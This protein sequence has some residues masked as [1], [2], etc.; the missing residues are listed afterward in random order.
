MKLLMN[1]KTKPTIIL[2]IFF[3]RGEKC[4]RLH[5]LVALR[6][7]YVGVVQTPGVLAVYVEPPIAFQYRLIKQRGLGAEERLHNKTIVGQRTDMEHLKNSNIP[8]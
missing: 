7:W 2:C 8:C 5:Q 1:S 6:Y 4:K 3:I